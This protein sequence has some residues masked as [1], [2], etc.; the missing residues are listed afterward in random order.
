M[1]IRVYFG[2]IINLNGEKVWWRYIELILF[3]NR[4]NLLC[5]MVI[6]G[7]DRIIRKYLIFTVRFCKKILIIHI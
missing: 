2:F 7:I 3:F 4:M 6:L 5:G 1:V